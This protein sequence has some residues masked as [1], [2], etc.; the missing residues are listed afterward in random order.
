[1]PYTEGVWVVVWCVK[2]RSPHNQDFLYPT[3]SVF[4]FT[5]HNA[6][7]EVEFSTQPGEGADIVGIESQRRLEEIGLQY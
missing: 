7:K 5:R 4:A 6:R 2:E 3:Q 1:M